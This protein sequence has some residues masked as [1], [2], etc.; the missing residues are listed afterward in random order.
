MATDDQRAGQRDGAA[1]TRA[2]VGHGFSALPTGARLDRYVVESVIAAG[3]FGITYVARHETLGRI[4]AIKEHFPRQFA[5]RDGATSEVRPTDP[6]TYTW[7]LDRF[8]QEG[9]SLGRCKHPNVVDVTDVFEANGTAYMVLGYE[10]GV[11]MKTWRDQLGRTPTQAEIDVW[12]GRLLDALQFIHNAGLLHRDLA[13]DNILIRKDNT[14]CL[15]DFGA[16]RQALAERSQMMSAIVKGGF[17]PPEQYTSSGRSQGPWS[18]VYA[19]GATL[20]RTITGRTPP[21]ATERQ[22]EDDLKPIAEELPQDHGF[23]PGFL[24][25]I[26]RAMRLRMTERPQSIGALRD[27][28]TSNAAQAEAPVV[29]SSV[30]PSAAVAAPGTSRSQPANSTAS[31]SANAAPRHVSFTDIAD[32]G[33]RAP[34]SNSARRLVP[35]LVASSIVLML[36][37]VAAWSL[38]RNGTSSG[39]ARVAPSS[40]ASPSSVATAPPVPSPRLGASQA[41]SVPP[42]ATTSQ[43]ATARP[44]PAPSQPAATPSPAASPPPRPAQSVLPPDLAD[45]L[46]ADDLTRIVNLEDTKTKAIEKARADANRDDDQRQGQAALAQV[47]KGGSVAFDFNEPFGNWRCRSVQV[48]DLGVFAYNY[49]RCEIARTGKVYVFHKTTGSQ[50]KIGRL[51]RIDSNRYLYLGQSYIEGNAVPSGYAG[52]NKSDEVGILVKPASGRLRLELPERHLGIE[53]IELVK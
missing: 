37:G 50:R 35:L 45:L 4:V 3:G 36:G 47:L 40:S 48:G 34:E 22:L 12:L 18:D 53:F 8:L 2:S 27:L 28:L 6:P 26:D 5:Y 9:R 16:A 33:A 19:F 17:S 44:Q 42:P 10:D 51:L 43:P 30:A 21:E 29:A 14:P 7:A 38:L 24:A 39:S 46:S 31:A 1:A 25:G 11:S 13:P 20:Y 15:I 41:T 23:R 32:A 52:N 49:F